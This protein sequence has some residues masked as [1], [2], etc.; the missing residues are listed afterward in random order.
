MEAAVTQTGCDSCLAHLHASHMP[1][2]APPVRLQLRRSS[3]PQALLLPRQ[4]EQCSD[5]AALLRPLNGVAHLR[6]QQAAGT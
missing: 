3:G 4:D 2:H 6:Q 1:G 5:G